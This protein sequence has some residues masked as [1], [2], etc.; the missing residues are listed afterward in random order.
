MRWLAFV[1]GCSSSTV[2]HTDFRPALPE[3]TFEATAATGG[4]LVTGSVDVVHSFVVSLDASALPPSEPPY[5][6]R[7]HSVRLTKTVIVRRE[8]S[9]TSAEVGV[10]RQGTRSV[11]QRSAD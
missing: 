9:A 4:R 6:A 8:P 2:A 7:I 3:V 11:A 1:V 5:P 10:V